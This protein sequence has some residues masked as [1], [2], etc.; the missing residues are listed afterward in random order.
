[1][2]N[3]HKNIHV[4][5]KNMIHEVSRC[6]KYLIISDM[7][8][9][10]MFMAFFMLNF[11]DALLTRTAELTVITQQMCEKVESEMLAWKSDP[12]IRNGNYV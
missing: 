8:P 7:E 4:V 2:F 10:H 11:T 5:N 3:K 1:M 9:L 6:F 12:E